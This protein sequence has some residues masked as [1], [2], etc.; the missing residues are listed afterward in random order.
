MTANHVNT[1]HWNKKRNFQLN[2]SLLQTWC[3]YSYSNTTWWEE[4]CGVVKMSTFVDLIKNIKPRGHIARAPPSL[5]F[6]TSSVNSLLTPPQ[7]TLSWTTLCVL[8]YGA[9]KNSLLIYTWEHNCW[10]LGCIHTYLVQVMP[11]PS[12]EGWPLLFSYQSSRGS[13]SPPTRSII[14][15]SYFYQIKS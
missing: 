8:H 15:F 14:Q 3:A 10:A 11:S 12:P 13:L 9:V 1:S 6:I 4:N 2:S 5:H 7:T